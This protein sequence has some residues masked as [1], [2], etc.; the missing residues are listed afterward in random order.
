MVL[1]EAVVLEVT[2]VHM[3]QNHQEVEN[4]LNLFY[5]LHLEHLILLLLVVVLLHMNMQL[6]QQLLLKDQHLLLLVQI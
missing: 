1:V 2:E 6:L 3:V 4:L 5:H